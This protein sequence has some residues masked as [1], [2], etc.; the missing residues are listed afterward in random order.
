[1]TAVSGFSAVGKR[2]ATSSRHSARTPRTGGLAGVA[3]GLRSAASKQVV[4]MGQVK[5]R[6]GGHRFHV[7]PNSSPQYRAMALRASRVAAWLRC[8]PVRREVAF[9]P[10]RDAGHRGD[11]YGRSGLSAHSSVSR[12]TK[13]FLDPQANKSKTPVRPSVSRCAASMCSW[14]IAVRCASG[15]YTATYSIRLPV[16]GNLNSNRCTPVSSESNFQDAPMSEKSENIECDPA[17]ASSVIRALVQRLVLKRSEVQG[18][19][20]SGI[21]KWRTTIL[22]ARC[23]EECYSLPGSHC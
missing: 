15:T 23:F 22:A 2:V 5:L 17:P 1:M 4:G 8:G 6:L 16:S 11:T 12:P 14:R 18:D 19:K 9:P 20:R 7:A 13:R 21:R 3:P 10:A